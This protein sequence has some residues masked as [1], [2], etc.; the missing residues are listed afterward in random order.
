MS[1][2]KNSNVA[3]SWEFVNMINRLVVVAY[4]TMLNGIQ[5]L[6]GLYGDIKIAGEA[7]ERK[8]TK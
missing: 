4:V 2:H 8:E 5:A 6:I 3:L 7:S 1:V